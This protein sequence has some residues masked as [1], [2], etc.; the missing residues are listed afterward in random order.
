LLINIKEY[1]NHARDVVMQRDLSKYRAIIVVSGDGLIHEILNGILARGDWQ[2]S[3][4]LPIGQIP[5]GSANGFAS[6][7]AYASQEEFQIS[8][9]EVFASTMA[10][11]IEK[12]EPKP[13]DVISLQLADGSFRHSFMNIEWAIVADVDKESEQY[14]FL[15][16]FR[17]VL[18]FVIRILS[19]DI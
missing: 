7:M 16:A 19:K 11:L 15:G 18:G 1:Q 6:S 17:F 10:F 9:L 12:F 3:I 13:M 5:A 2:T 4:K 14:R 8:R